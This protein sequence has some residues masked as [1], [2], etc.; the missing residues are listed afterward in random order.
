MTEPIAFAASRRPAIKAV[1]LAAGIGT[2][3]EKAAGFPPKILL[4][5]GGKTLLQR[6]VEILRH[7]GVGELVL[8]IG[9]QADS[10]RREIADIGAGDFV[11]TVD[12]PKHAK[13]AAYTMW[14][15]R[16]EFNGPVLFMDGDVLYDHCLMAK[17]LDCG[18]QTCFA[19]DRK[20]RPGD[21]PVKICFRDGRI[22]DFHKQPTAFHDDFAEW[23]GFLRLSAE[24][25]SL[26]E[27]AMRPYIET[28]RTD[29]IYEQVFRDILLGSADGAFG[30][31]DITGLPWTEIDFPHDLEYARSTIFPALVALP[32]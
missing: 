22:V 3:L 16:A 24:V 20:V 7:L 1:M 13:G 25:T 12:C 11:R 28:G 14:G 26:V 15:L 29:F 18:H 31:A 17:L 4:R 2:R 23:I 19:M 6:H 30:T 32:E 21:D 27:A 10:I 5:F 9:Y 8:G